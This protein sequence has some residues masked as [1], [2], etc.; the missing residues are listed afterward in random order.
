MCIRIVNM[1]KRLIQKSVN[2]DLKSKIV[3]ISGPRQSG[4]TTL[5]KAITDNNEYLNFDTTSHRKILINQAWRRDVDL[6]ILDELHKMKNWKAWLKGV[7]DDEGVEPALIVTG[8]ARLD[9][10]KKMGDSLAGRYFPY[11]LHPLTL[12]ELKDIKNSEKNFKR[13]MEQGGFPEPFFSNEK[14]FYER[15]QKTHLDIILRQDLIDIESIKRITDIEM[16]IELL[17][18]KVG[19]LVSYQSLSEDLQVAPTTVKRWLNLLENLFVIF[20]VT[21]WTKNITRSLQK[22]S[23][24]YFF[25][26]GQ[27]NDINKGARFENLIANELLSAVHFEQDTKGR[28]LELH[29]LRNKDKDEL[30]F[31]IVENKNLIIAIEAKWSDDNPASAFKKFLGKENSVKAYQV[32]AKLNKE[33][34]YPFG[35]KIVPANTW[36]SSFRL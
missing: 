12:F 3:L 25:D 7:Y 31:A 5:A 35:L 34:H 18:D 27:V 6:V 20:K 13:L 10:A 19:S 2:K 30:D 8:S 22:A 21:P 33:K 17:R 14:Y 15:W 32:V 28:K 16:L 29:F 1:Q 11:R 23:K 36:L 24:Y 9:I 26:N 4:K